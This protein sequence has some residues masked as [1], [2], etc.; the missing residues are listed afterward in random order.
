MGGWEGA[1]VRGWIGGCLCERVGGWGDAC[2]AGWTGGACV[3][4]WMGGCLCGWVDGG[5]ACS[6][7][8]K[9]GCLCG[10]IGGCL[11]GWVGGWRRH[12]YLK[13]LAGM[14]CP[15]E[16]RTPPPPLTLQQPPLPLPSPPLLA[17]G[18]PFRT[19]CS[20]TLQVRIN[21]ERKALLLRRVM[22][23]QKTEEVT[24]AV[25]RADKE[26]ERAVKKRKRNKGKVN[27]QAQQHLNK[28]LNQ[29]ETKLKEAITELGLQTEQELLEMWEQP[30]EP[31]FVD[32]R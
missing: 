3:Y 29:H 12:S 13:A 22:A 14:S 6:G 20:A 2:V 31:L 5:G 7:G 26:F 11:Y 1:V 16:P 25:Q 18:T 19:P 4:G 9:G 28:M 27:E 24:C 21:N 23:A 10:W 17:R 30:P 15:R 8:W 32:H